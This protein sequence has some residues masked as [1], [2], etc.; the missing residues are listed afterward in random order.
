MIYS[1]LSEKL[2][3]IK[4][5]LLDADGVLTDGGI[6]FG[7]DG[8]ETK[9]FNVK[10]G[11]GLRLAM[12]NGI[13]VGIVTGRKSPALGHRCRDLGIRLLFEDVH[14]KAKMLEEIIERTGIAAG[15][16]AYVGDDLPDLALMRHVGLSIAVADAHEIVRKKADWTTSAAGGRGAVREVCDA[17]L[18]ARGLLNKITAQF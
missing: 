18:N 16:T 9:I 8:S 15:Q 11:L 3:S 6:V 14:D 5:L 4:L 1:A 2:K 7:D 17:I 13:K 10:D 12:E